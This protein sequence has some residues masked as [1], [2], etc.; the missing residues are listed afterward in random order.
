MGID[1]IGNERIS[2]AEIEA[3]LKSFGVY[4]GARVSSVE[5][6][7]V[8]NKMMTRFDDIAWIGINIKGSRAYIEVKE[9]LDT[10][11]EVD[12]DVPCNIVATRDGVIK[13]IRVRAG[14][15]MVKLNDMVEKGN[16]LVSGAMDSGV[17]GIRYA[18]ADGE[19]YAET[20]YKRSREY[21]LEFTE[22]TYTEQPKKRCSITVLGKKINLFLNDK[23]PFEYCEKSTESKD[24]H[25]FFGKGFPVSVTTDTYAEYVPQKKK[26]T[27]AEAAAIGKTELCQELDRELARHAKILNRNVTYRRVSDNSVEVTA[28]YLCEEDIA[29]KVLIDKTENIDYN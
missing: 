23:Q 16:L 22:K 29:S 4:R 12:K 10:K 26:R 24:Y 6:K 27:E 28:E 13:N 17:V 8:Q 19:I 18:H 21:P 25:L 1:I 7:L 3:G 11:I 14:Q 5:P 9:R 20:T 2:A 15:T